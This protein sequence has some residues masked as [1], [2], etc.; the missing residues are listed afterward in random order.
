MITL[1]LNKMCLIISLSRVSLRVRV[2]WPSGLP[3]TSLSLIQRWQVVIG[4]LGHSCTHLFHCCSQ[5]NSYLFVFFFHAN[6]TFLF[7][8]ISV[9][10]SH[11]WVWDYFNFK[12]SVLEFIMLFDLI[13]LKNVTISNWSIISDVT[14]SSATKS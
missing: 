14:I 5:K 2:V 4:A 3:V 10:M 11:I 8:N 7:P 1:S 12:T 9:F 6:K 13:F